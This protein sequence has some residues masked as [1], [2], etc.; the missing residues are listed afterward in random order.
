MPSIVFI[1]NIA[2]RIHVKE[3]PQIFSLVFNLLVSI[4]RLLALSK[5]VVHV[6]HN[7]HTLQSMKCMR[8]TKKIK[9][10]K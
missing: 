2:H 4:L 8:S 7:V 5:T 1:Q 9:K 6:T 10:I 3:I